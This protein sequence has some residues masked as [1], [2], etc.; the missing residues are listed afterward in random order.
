MKTFKLNIQLFAGGGVEA[1]PEAVASDGVTV[2][3]VE[4]TIETDNVKDEKDT[5]IFDNKENNGEEE[6]TEVENPE[7]E[8]EEEEGK[9]LNL[10]EDDLSYLGESPEAVLEELRNLGVQQEQLE[11]FVNLA[12]KEE[13]VLTS[14]LREYENLINPSRDLLFNNLDGDTKA[15][16]KSGQLENYLIRMT[17][18]DNITNRVNEAFTTPEQ[19]K[20]LAELSK[21]SVNSP[22]GIGNPMT[23]GLYTKQEYQRDLMA[24]MELVDS[25]ETYAANELMATI[26][27]KKK[28]IGVSSIFK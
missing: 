12:K 1:S 6:V 3:E 27:H 21:G 17:G 20:I 23:G 8:T 2:N 4:A 28:T 24:H 19:Y 25:G 16:I 14:K 18:D 5:N 10:A 13:E 7:S 9:L 15:T 22:A 11:Y 26:K